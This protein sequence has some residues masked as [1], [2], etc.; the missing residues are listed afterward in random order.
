MR[1]K[2]NNSEWSIEL[3]DEATINN[4]MKSDGTMGVTIYKSQR[5]LL[6]KDQANI[7]K[8]LKHELTHV[9]LY[10]YGH[11]QD[12]NTTYG[13]EGVCEIVAS[14]NEFINDIVMKYINEYNITSTIEQKIDDIL[15]DGKSILKRSR[16]RIFAM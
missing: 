10:E 9:W 3:V 4:E 2:C 16:K 14:S 13:Y 7:I 12:D 11:T 6:L 15:I 1:F 5:I 8:T